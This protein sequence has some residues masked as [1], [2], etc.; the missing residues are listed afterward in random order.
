MQDE[1]VALE[2]LAQLT[3]QRQPARIGRVQADPPR[4]DGRLPF[5]R[6]PQSRLRA[7]Q[8]QL[9]VAA[10][11]RRDGDP[12]RAASVQREAGD[13]NGLQQQLAHGVADRES[14]GDVL[15]PGK[16]QAELVVA[17]PGDESSGRRAGHEAAPHLIEHLIAAGGSQGVVD[18]AEPVE[19]D[20]E[21]RGGTGR[22]H[23]CQPLSQQAPVGQ[24]R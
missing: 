10:V 3:D 24:A 18:L 7:A 2:R 23:L 9:G 11:Q 13:V 20:D 12:D 15:D 4:L 14:V 5:L 19:V 21:D 16:Q 22:E 8:Q 17:D 1:L 6:E